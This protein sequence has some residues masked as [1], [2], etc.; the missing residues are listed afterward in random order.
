MVHQK[1][2]GFTLIEL[3]VVVAII[4]TLFALILPQ[5]SHSSEVSNRASCA[6]NLKQIGTAMSLY[7]SVPAY[8]C[9][10]VDSANPD[11]LKSLGMLYRD[12]VID[13]RVFS[14]ASHPT[15]IKLVQNLQPASKNPAAGN[16]DISMS[17]FGYDPGYGTPNV[18]HNSN[19]ATAIVAA[20]IL[21][22]RLS[23]DGI[24]SA[25][26]KGRGE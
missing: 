7:E 12:F 14:C 21:N 24:V 18:P 1:S 2:S 17:A 19:D 15:V 11:P 25:N 3:M 6:S 23:G 20:D 9:F 16:L 10:P 22:G 13:A 8:N 4:C 5:I 26:H